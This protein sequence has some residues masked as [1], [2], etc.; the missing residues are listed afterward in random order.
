MS[1]ILTLLGLASLAHTLSWATPFQLLVRPLFRYPLLEELL[2][3]PLCMSF[4]I[5]LFYTWDLPSAGLCVL[6]T[7]LVTAL[8]DSL[9]LR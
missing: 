8:Y 9:P 3:C 6:L 2:T 1:D 5:S 7:R 4:W